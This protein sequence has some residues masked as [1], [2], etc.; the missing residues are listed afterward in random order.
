[1]CVC[2]PVAAVFIYICQLSMCV[3]GCH[4]SEQ[5]VLAEHTAVCDCRLCLCCTFCTFMHEANTHTRIHTHAMLT[6]RDMVQEQRK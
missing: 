5:S 2:V 6:C 3:S 1:M 4:C